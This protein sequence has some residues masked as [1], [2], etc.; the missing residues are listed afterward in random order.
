ME[1]S[2]YT[3]HGHDMELLQTGLADM[4]TWAIGDSL[5]QFI[6]SALPEGASLLELGSGIGTQELAKKFQMTSIEHYSG[7]IGIYD[8]NYIHAPLIDDWYDRSI[9][10][11][12]LGNGY[13]GILVDGPSG[14]ERRANFIWN[15]DLFD[16]SKWIFFDDIH[17]E[18]ECSCFIKLA[19]KLGRQHA[20]VKDNKGKAFGVIVPKDVSRETI[21]TNILDKLQLREYIPTEHTGERV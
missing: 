18:P 20:M 6:Y 5:L 16:L 1:S 19:D 9:I 11:S 2:G 10:S 13:A 4:G 8:T 14:S 15:V 21:L 7:W 17:R 12:S 3:E